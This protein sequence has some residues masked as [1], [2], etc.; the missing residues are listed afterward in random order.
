MPDKTTAAG[1]SLR[2]W[3]QRKIEA[4]RGA[5]SAQ[6]EKG[7]ESAVGPE[8]EASS[9]SALQRDARAPAPAPQ[10]AVAA[11]STPTFPVPAAPAS[12]EVALPELPPIDS[13]TIDS[14]F[15]PFMQRSVDESVRRSALKKLFQD[16]RFNIMDG[17]DVYIDDYSK[18]DPIDPAIVRT[19]V[20]ARYIFN[21]P[22]TRV[23]EQGFVEDVPDDPSNEARER[24]Q[25]AEPQREQAADVAA[26]TSDAT[27]AAGESDAVVPPPSPHD[28]PSVESVTVAPAPSDEPN[29]S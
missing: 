21:P 6:D 27:V 17:L 22:V 1:F 16:P 15:S 28:A 18:P 4:S 26:S 8:R 23:N 25:T 5:A 7:A 11:Q 10:S 2:R 9:D 19:L 14:D 3:S 29:R 12:P 24:A 20:Q 13:L